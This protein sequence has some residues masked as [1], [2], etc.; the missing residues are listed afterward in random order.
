MKTLPVLA[1][2]KQGIRP[3]RQRNR[4]MFFDVQA[5]QNFVDHV[6]A[7]YGGIYWFFQIAW[8][9][10]PLFLSSLAVTLH[11]FTLKTRS[12]LILLSI[13][14]VV[15]IVPMVGMVMY[16]DDISTPLQLVGGNAMLFF[17]FFLAVAAVIIFALAG[18]DEMVRSER[19][20]DAKK[21]VDPKTAENPLTPLFLR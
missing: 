15:V 19:A 11:T 14:L 8:E 9:L 17:H 3:T 5:Y 10:M 21:N 1:E 4:K 18:F 6:N 13:A 12:C 16:P 2:Y 20:L 7:T